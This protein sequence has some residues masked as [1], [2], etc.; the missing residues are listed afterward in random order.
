MQLKKTILAVLLSVLAISA[1]YGANAEI[2]NLTDE[3]AHLAGDAAHAA[4]DA[5][6]EG[7]HHGLPPNAV[8]VFESFPYITN[9]MI[10]VWIVAALSAKR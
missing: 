3:A 8:P 6:D 7:G 10:V 4:H 1:G 5:H 2:S 9:S